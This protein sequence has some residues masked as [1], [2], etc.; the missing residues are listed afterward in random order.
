MRAGKP[1]VTARFVANTRAHLERPEVPTGD[2]AAELRL[3]RSLGSTPFLYETKAWRSRMARRT[4]FF[5]R[6]TLGALEAGTTQM[7]IV[8]AGYDGRPAPFPPRGCTCYGAHHPST[9][10]EK[11]N[12]LAAAGADVSAIRFVAI[13]LI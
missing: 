10:S 6:L 3:Y 4:R 13:D 9:Q 7:V 2:A 12:G 8:G 1:S 11:G 5:D